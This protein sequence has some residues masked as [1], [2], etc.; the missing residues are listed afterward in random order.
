MWIIKNLSRG[1]APLKTDLRKRY[2]F[3]IRKRALDISV[4]ALFRSICP[5]RENKKAVSRRACDHPSRHDF[6]F[7]SHG[8]FFLNIL[9]RI[10]RG[11]G[12][13]RRV[14]WRHQWL[15]QWGI[16]EFICVLP[17]GWASRRS[18]KP[19]SDRT[20]DDLSSSK[21]SN[22]DSRA[23][24]RQSPPRACISPPFY[25]EPRGDDTKR[26]KSE[27]NYLCA[28]TWFWYTV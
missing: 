26:G 24:L 13:V 19:G 18:G 14:S 2:H 25:P 8:V 10:R 27:W 1:Y 7:F 20:A 5:S 3:N 21:M 22:R 16:R 11:G 28:R 6:R 12:K 15:W 9:C 23:M 4:R 17:A